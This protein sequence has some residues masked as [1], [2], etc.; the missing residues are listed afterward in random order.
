MHSILLLLVT[1]S[2]CLVG[3]LVDFSRPHSEPDVDIA[4]YYNK[5]KA[6][7]V[8]QKLKTN[9]FGSYPFVF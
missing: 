3:K 1:L 4:M 9:S 7:E 8:I 5:Q 6:K 2:L